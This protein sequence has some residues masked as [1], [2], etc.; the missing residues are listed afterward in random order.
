MLFPA[1][2]ACHS[3]SFSR[4]APFPLTVKGTQRNRALT[5]SP[6]NQLPGVNH[7]NA[8]FWVILLPHDELVR[9]ILLFTMVTPLKVC[10]QH[11]EK[12]VDND[13]AATDLLPY[14]SQLDSQ[15]LNS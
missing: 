13:L 9:K 2:T 5:Y 3:V 4:R 6:K 14:S 12:Y 1:A 8:F 15:K 11:L 10:T 7:R